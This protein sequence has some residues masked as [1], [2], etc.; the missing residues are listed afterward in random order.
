MR[1]DVTYIVRAGL[2]SKGLDSRRPSNRH[3]IENTRCYCSNMRSG[4]E[5]SFSSESVLDL[6]SGWSGL[7]RLARRRDLDASTF[8]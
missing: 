1:V 5:G 7:G 3:S 8:E 6:E 4:W 2:S